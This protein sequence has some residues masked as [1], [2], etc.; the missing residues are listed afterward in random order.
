M[1]DKPKKARMKPLRKPTGGRR[2]RSI[3]VFEHARDEVIA[4]LDADDLWLYSSHL[5]AQNSIVCSG[6][7]QVWIGPSSAR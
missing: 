4:P 3:S 2:Q 6:T 1:R 5:V 7:K